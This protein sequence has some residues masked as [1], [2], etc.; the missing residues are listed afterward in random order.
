MRQL[1]AVTGINLRNNMQ[2]K[3]LIVVFVGIG[4]L[5]VGIAGV[6]AGAF[7]LGPEADDGDST[8][9]E[10]G[11]SL[12]LIGYATTVVIIGASYSVLFSV[13]LTRDKIRGTLESLLATPTSARQVWLGK[14]LA[15][16]LPGAI[17][18]NVLALGLTLVLAYGYLGSGEVEW[19]GWLLLTTHVAVPLVY[20]GLSLVVHV[21]GL[22]GRVANANVL[23]VVFL[24]GFTA[25][26]LNLA[27]RG[28]VDAGSSAF[29]AINVG[30]AAVLVLLAVVFARKLTKERIV[31][32]CRA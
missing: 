16:F 3:A 30:A 29:L 24:P 5:L 31:L 17:V 23:N 1:L 6:V 14:S 28:V 18:G 26:M 12:G 9:A 22:L 11:N 4:V 21:A 15:L 10:L 13:P 27:G 32:S 7:V 20:T 2:S 25:T 19:N 8:P